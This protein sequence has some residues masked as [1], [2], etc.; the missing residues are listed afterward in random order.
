V[1]EPLVVGLLEC[2]HVR[3][4][5]RLAA[6]GDYVDLFAGLF[7]AHAPEITLKRFDVIGGDLPSDPAECN[8]WLCSGSRHGAYD[9]FEWIE[10]LSGFI[11]DVHEAVVPFAGI[12]F[13]HQ[14]LAQALGGR[15]EKAASGWGAGIRR[16]HI[17]APAAFMAPPAHHLDLHFMHQDQVV[18]LP[19][20]AEV[21]GHAEHCPV[22]VFRVGE[23]MLG[24]Q[25]H[26][27]FTVP[28]AEALLVDR[29][30]L[31]G[32][33][34]TTE[35]LATLTCP[36]DEALAARWIAN[37]VAAGGGGGGIGGGGDLSDG[38]LA[39]R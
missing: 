8:G 10:R 33:S 14:I 19:P 16:V 29:E 23:A 21:L 35:A 13:G 17:D 12:C 27:E 2:D 15:V 9:A 28:Y 34:E 4:R 7:A 30:E 32:G 26:P 24:I 38:R 22:A 3:E 39:E 5:F 36:T 1:S 20:G 11:R 37:L 6:G 18:E 31:L 25:A